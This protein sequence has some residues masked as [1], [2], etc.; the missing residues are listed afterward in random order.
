MEA[1][2]RALVNVDVQPNPVP[3]DPDVLAVAFEA[4]AHPKLVSQMTHESLVLR[5]KSLQYA[6]QAMSAPREIACFLEAGI[7]KSL[8]DAGRDCFTGLAEAHHEWIDAM[9]AGL[10]AHER[11]SLFDLLGVLKLSLA[12][13]IGEEA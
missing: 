8:T 2:L 7:V 4:R 12:S 6:C 10:S 3:M 1:N 5:Q 11:R 13:D 9:L